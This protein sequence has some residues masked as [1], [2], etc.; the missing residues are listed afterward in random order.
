MDSS[1][2]ARRWSRESQYWIQEAI[3]AD[4]DDPDNRWSTVFSPAFEDRA[5][6]EASIDLLQARLP[7]RLRWPNPPLFGPSN[8]EP[9]GWTDPTRE[10]RRLVHESQS[11]QTISRWTSCRRRPSCPFTSSTESSRGKTSWL[12]E[13]STPLRRSGESLRKASSTSCA[14]TH[15]VK[16]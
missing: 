16:A 11:P 15:A 10:L 3:G 1:D 13:N 4:R 8:P 2:E 6:A 5:D 9:P 12:S 7:F 14:S